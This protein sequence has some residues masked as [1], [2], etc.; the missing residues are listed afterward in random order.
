[1][2][3][4]RHQGMRGPVCAH[5]VGTSMGGCF[6][7]GGRGCRCVAPVARKPLRFHSRV[8][9]LWAGTAG[10][11]LIRARGSAGKCAGRARRPAPAPAPAPGRGSPEQGPS[12]CCFPGSPSGLSGACDR[13]PA[14]RP[15]APASRLPRPQ[16]S[17]DGAPGSRP[18]PAALTA[19]PRSARRRRARGRGG[20]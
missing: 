7:T 1:M 3:N 16:G 12:R 19:G 11:A 17:G 18:G 8:E 10:R 14:P 4:T 5:H 2:S 15:G 20:S 6:P 9:T 13:S